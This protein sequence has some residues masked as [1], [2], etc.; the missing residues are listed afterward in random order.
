MQAGGH[1][2]PFPPLVLILLDQRHGLG[3]LQDIREEDHFLEVL[4]LTASPSIHI[5]GLSDKSRPFSNAYNSKTIALRK[6][7][8]N[9]SES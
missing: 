2:H 3:H 6:A 7:C 5:Q 9:A 4:K 1:P 8:F